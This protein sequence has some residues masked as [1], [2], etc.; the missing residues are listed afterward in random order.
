MNIVDIVTIKEKIPLF[1][2]EEKAERIE[3][4]L[5]EEAGFELV[6]QKDLYKVGDKAV[7]IQPDYCLSDI[8][9]FK[10]FIRPNGD[11]SKS[12]LGKVEGKPRRIRAKKFNLSKDPNG[13]PVYSNGILLR[14][15]EVCYYIIRKNNKNSFDWAR[16]NYNL[17]EELEITKYEEPE[18]KNKYGLNTGKSLKFPENIYKTDEVN[19]LNK[20][21]Q[22]QFPITLI[23]TLKIDGSSITIGR[24]N[25]EPIICSRNM[26]KPLTY[27]KVVGRR[28]KTL[29]EKLLFWQKPDLLIKEEVPNTDDDFVKY[30]LPVLDKIKNCGDFL[31]RG[32]LNGGSLK[33]SGNKY[34]PA[35]N[36]PPNIKF[37]TLDYINKSGVAEKQSRQELEYL[38]DMINIELVPVIFN[39]EFN[40]LSEIIDTCN[41]YFKDNLVEGIVVRTPDSKFSAKVMNL[42]YDSLK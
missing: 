24:I 17:I 25:G 39:K 42:S 34:N 11:E 31:L 18:S 22:I 28:S 15:D 12:M 36:E 14:L 23:G 41:E 3:L 10:S 1:K 5:L 38:R 37:Y 20:L 9:L 35:R 26:R 13:E 7:Y 21:G 33:G 16:G 2:G 30:A 32:E 19:I 4:I 29:V 27:T 8:P 6:A 40:S